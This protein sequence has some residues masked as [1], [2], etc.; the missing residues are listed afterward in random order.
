MRN[1]NTEKLTVTALLLAIEIIISRFLGISTPIVK[2]SFS[3]I[4]LSM[5]GILYGPIYCCIAGGLA[6]FIGA[7]LFPVGAYFP[8]YTITAALTGLTYGLFLHRKNSGWVNIIAAVLMVNALWRLG[9]NSYWV[10]MTTGKAM[11]V[12]MGA[13]IIK[14]FITMPIEVLVIGFVKEKICTKFTNF[15]SD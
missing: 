8:G 15:L 10:H 3:F 4:P 2:I 9:L 1:K 6:D 5:I 12:I 7:I 13:R 14:T 11:P